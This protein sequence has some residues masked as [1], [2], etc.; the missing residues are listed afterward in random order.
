[1][2]EGQNIKYAYGASGFY[3]SLNENS[4]L[5]NEELKKLHGILRPKKSAL[6]KEK[7]HRELD[8]TN[9]LK[10]SDGTKSYFL[11]YNSKLPNKTSKGNLMFLLSIFKIF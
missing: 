2:A 3:T 7:D 1:M 6:I 9:P 8:L 11:R 10:H 5:T 4:I